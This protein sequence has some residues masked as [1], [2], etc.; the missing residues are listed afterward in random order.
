MHILDV[1][2]PGVPRD[3]PLRSRD[4]IVE[5]LSQ[6]SAFVYQRSQRQPEEGQGGGRSTQLACPYPAAVGIA[7]QLSRFELLSTLERKD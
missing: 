1:P 2:T 4:V 3:H 5:F 7:P 6:E